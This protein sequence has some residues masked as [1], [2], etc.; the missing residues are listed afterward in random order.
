MEPD[1]S[2]TRRIS[3]VL[4]ADVTGFSK[5]MG[6][7]D[8]RTAQAVHQFQALAKGVVAEATGQAE[9]V[10]GDALFATFESVVAAVDAALTIQERLAEEDFAGT[11]LQVRMGVHVGDVLLRDGRAFGDA[12]N[13]AARLQALA[14]PGTICIS[15]V[16]YRQVRNKFDVEFVDLG[17]QRLKNISDPVRAY[18]MVPRHAQAHPSH[19]GWR[20]V[21]RWV[22]AVVAAAALAGGAVVVAHYH[23]A[24]PTLP[25]RT[26][27]AVQ[28]PQSA[29][30]I[31][32]AAA[33]EEA[34]PI[35][36]GVMLFKAPGGD[37]ESDWR[38]EA[39]RD[40][41][42]TQ[43]SQLSRVKVYSKEFIDFLITR[44]GLTEIEAATQLGIKKMLSGS[45]VKV[46]DT[47]RI[48][49][50]VV[51]VASGVLEASYVT[52]GKDSEFLDLQ[53]KLTLG[54]IAKLNLPATDAEKQALLAKR[55][56]N[57][58]ALKLLLEAERGGVPPQGSGGKP[59]AQAPHSALPQWLAALRPAVARAEDG[60]PEA[61][62]HALLERYRQA[63][64]ARQLD[65]LASLH[66]QF[67]DEQ[68]AAQQRYFQNVRELKVVIENVDVAVVGDEAVV[69]YTRTDDFA[70][71]KTGRPMH[72]SV[73]VTKTLRQEQGE[74]KL[75]G[76][77]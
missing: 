26:T 72:A 21:P 45:F 57:E 22:A 56:T 58:D 73:R 70:D 54:V 49:T 77:K 23:A 29:E 39:L 59:A 18:L 74:W 37:A 48:E 14:R 44:K 50:H 35:A 60:S 2:F 16:V 19:V 20:L 33:H 17:A 52:A 34:A 71:A 13:I 15:D 67:T 40:G 25:A 68:R 41:L 1:S 61:A 32:A 65:A 6:E 30:E 12:I 36:L 4:L 9:A 5:L 47:L 11:P 3:A 75:A 28:A 31:E 24:A 53:S 69:S 27:T 76:G 38:R 8:E 66:T 51:D 62:I 63:T 43:L 10:A 42:N 7:D 55:N 46:D 64:E